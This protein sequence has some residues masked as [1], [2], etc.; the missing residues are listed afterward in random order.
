M[1]TSAKYKG[2]AKEVLPQKRILLV[3][4]GGT[5]GESTMHDKQFAYT[6]QGAPRA[7]LEHGKPLHATRRELHDAS[8]VL[9]R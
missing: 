4:F 9:F 5:K 3:R 2:Q 1:A 8:T 7:N 6:T